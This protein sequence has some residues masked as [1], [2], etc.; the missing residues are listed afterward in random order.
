MKDMYGRERQVVFI[1][2]FSDEGLDCG[3]LDIRSR[4]ML[5]LLRDAKSDEERL[6]LVRKNLY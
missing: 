4:E 2:N 5:R 3:D 6:D 1:E